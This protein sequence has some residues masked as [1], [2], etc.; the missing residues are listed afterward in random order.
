MSFM[1][2]RCGKTLSDGVAPNDIELRVYTDIEWEEKI[3]IGIINSVEIPHPK[4]PVWRCPKCE[5]IY[6]WDERFEK[7]IK[8]YSLE[9][10][11]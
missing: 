9:E 3:N 10:H 5:R 7:L 2:C 6:V 1:T 11:E 4:Y 8:I